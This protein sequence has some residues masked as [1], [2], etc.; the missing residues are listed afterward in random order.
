M[1]DNICC[2]P[3]QFTEKCEAAIKL[4]G[5]R[6]T[7]TRRL[8]IKLLDSSKVPLSANEIFDRLDK[9]SSAQL[10]SKKDFSKAPSTLIDKVTVYRILERFTELGLL[11][12]VGPNGKFIKCVHNHEGKHSMHLLCRCNNCGVTA[13]L[14][15]TPQLNINL[16]NLLKSLHFVTTGSPFQIDGIC[17]KC[18]K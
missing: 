7:N 9:Q 13:E 2:R 11:H 15:L 8:V 6:M 1:S 17:E 5:G 4:D 18:I 12:R 16:N 10:K 3:V 14:A